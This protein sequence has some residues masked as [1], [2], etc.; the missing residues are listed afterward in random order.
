MKEEQ[1]IILTETPF[2]FH[3]N[4]DSILGYSMRIM[5]LR[6]SRQHGVLVPDF[7]RSTVT[8]KVRCK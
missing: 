6:P 4:E 7:S 3:I 5:A 8:A 1:W 2:L